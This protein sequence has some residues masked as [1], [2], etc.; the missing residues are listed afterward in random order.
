MVRADRAAAQMEAARETLQ[1]ELRPLIL[2]A[3][4]HETQLEWER[5]LDLLRTVV[6]KAPQWFE[7]RVRLGSLLHTLARYAEAEPH[8][9]A[10]VRLETI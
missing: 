9:R 10:A 1:R 7:A 4:L 3:E 5:A 6:D 2:Q 8:N